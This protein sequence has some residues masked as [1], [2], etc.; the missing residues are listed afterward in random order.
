AVR[1]RCAALRTVWAKAAQTVTGI[2]SHS[3]KAGF[4]HPWRHETYPDWLRPARLV[5]N[6]DG[7]LSPAEFAL[8]QR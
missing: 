7:F 5:Q 3:V 2:Q 1:W 6:A 8:A 4:L